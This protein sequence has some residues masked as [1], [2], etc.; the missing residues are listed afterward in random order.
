M[1]IAYGEMI[2]YEKSG[3]AIFDTG[4][5]Y[6]NKFNFGILGHQP[7]ENELECVITS[8]DYDQVMIKWEEPFMFGQDKVTEYQ[9]GHY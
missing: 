7:L 5:T 9:T 8:H 2:V 3:T 6:Q 4:E 1:G